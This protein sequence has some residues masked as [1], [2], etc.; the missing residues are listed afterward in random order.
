MLQLIVNIKLFK[1]EVAAMDTY[2]TPKLNLAKVSTCILMGNTGK[3][4]FYFLLF[5][6]SIRYHKAFS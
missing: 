1:T 5:T 2:G 3:S 6:K 4:K